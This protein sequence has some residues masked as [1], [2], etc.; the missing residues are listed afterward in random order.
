MNE[1]PPWN[2]SH[3]LCKLRFHT[4][5]HT[6][7]A[8][9][10]LKTAKLRISMLGAWRI[11]PGQGSS[12]RGASEWWRFLSN[13]ECCVEEG[14]LSVSIDTICEEEQPSPARWHP[15]EMPLSMHS[16]ADGARCEQG[17]GLWTEAG[18]SLSWVSLKN[19]PHLQI[20]VWS[21]IQWRKVPTYLKVCLEG[22]LRQRVWTTC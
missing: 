2:Q 16:A 11:R 6:E 22:C 3:W 17:M 9:L 18:S 4:N 13:Q 8:T 15:R 19:K 1:A 5:T 10:P 14:G 12:R 7:N 21:T 20:L